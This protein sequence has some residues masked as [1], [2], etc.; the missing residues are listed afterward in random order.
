M[1]FQ[2]IIFAAALM[3]LLY[4]S[5]TDV[6]R[7]TVNS[8]LFIPLMAASTAFYIYSG[9]GPIF[10]ALSIILFFLTFLRPDSI[11]Y[12]IAGVAILIASVFVMRISGIQVGFN[13]TIMAVI[14]LSGFQ[15]RFFGI[16]D[17]KAL[18]SVSYSFLGLP[19]LT[20]LTTS[21]EFL[22]TIMPLSLAILIN[23]AILSMVFLP[24]ALFIMKRK[25]SGG[26]APP[27]MMNYDEDFFQR[28][29]GKFAVRELG[30]NRYLAYRTPFFIPIT[31]GFL[32][33]VIAGLWFML[34]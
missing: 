32:L 24:Y 20:P 4:G 21:Q 13:L 10:I 3:T 5:Y 17:I 9:T 1:Q 14:Y 12:P 18:V 34:I 28:N 7:R 19:F 27:F 26:V 6:R 22:F 29:R 25:S 8:F 33:T 11:L 30:G 2:I 15:E 31:G 23:V 16:G